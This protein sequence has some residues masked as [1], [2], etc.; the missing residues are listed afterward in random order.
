M[1]NLAFIQIMGPKMDNFEISGVKKQKFRD[2]IYGRFTV[3]ITVG[4]RMGYAWVTGEFRMS[5]R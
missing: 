1:L 5:H 3:R 4:L 2:E